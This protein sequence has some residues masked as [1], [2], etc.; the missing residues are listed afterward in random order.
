MVNIMGSINSMAL[1][2]KLPSFAS[3]K[4]PGN[5][6]ANPLSIVQSAENPLLNRASLGVKRCLRTLIFIG[7]FGEI[8]Q[9]M[10]LGADDR[11]S[12][13]EEIRQEA[14]RTESDPIGHSLPLAGHWNMGALPNGFNPDYQMKMIEQGH[15][16]LPWFQM[17]DPVRNQDSTYYVGAIKKAAMLGLPISLVGTQWEKL[18]ST[19]P[20]FFKLP[21]DQ[22][23][24]VVSLLGITLPKVSPFGP[25]EPWLQVGRRWT[26][27]T[28]MAALQKWYPNPPLVLFVSNNEHN[29]L[30]WTE[31]EIDQRYVKQYG[32]GQ[33][34]N[35]K[36]RVIGDGWVSRYR[37]LLLGMREAL[38]PEWAGKSRFIGYNALQTWSYGLQNSW[39][40]YS[41]HTEDRNSPWPLVWEGASMPYYMYD[42][43]KAQNDYTVY[44]PQVHA[45]NWLFMLEEARKQS[46][47]FWFELSTWDGHGE[48]DDKRQSLAKTGG[49]YNPARY[50][51]LVQFGAWLVRPRVVREFRFWKETL[52]DEV[53]YFDAVM[54]VVDRV[55]NQ[56]DLRRFWRKGELLA[57]PT[58]Q[59]PFQS[60]IPLQHQTINRW[61]LL[62]TNLDP[63]LPWS[64]AT[65]LP[66]YAIALVLGNAPNREWLVYGFSPLAERG[67]V[68]VVIPGYREVSISATP[69]GTFSLVREGSEDTEL[70]NPDA[71]SVASGTL[72]DKPK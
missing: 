8:N 51:G 21:T 46:P 20:S 37:Q 42:F 5:D 64:K 10:G 35:F 9:V 72:T 63:A 58:R 25:E 70:L 39:D 22:N 53:A 28:M 68:K 41:L 66:V 56:P 45:M 12:T 33:D 29:R 19:D 49:G 47:E 27:G 24:N 34:D 6:S 57:N 52:K 40:R 30:L 23:P 31:A 60:E 62:N 18:L 48:D 61:Y 67:N 55:H 4:Y 65:E 14:I 26:S 17:P 59:H 71:P 16:L 54:A 50:G 3:D 36:R 11:L 13:V 69:S 1:A 44:S 32:L 15:Y 43:Q 38:S 2:N 7:G